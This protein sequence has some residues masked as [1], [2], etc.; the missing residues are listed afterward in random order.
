MDKLA[1]HY[2]NIPDWSKKI[3]QAWA[4][5]VNPPG[6]NPF[7]GAKIIGRTYM[8]DAPS[9]TLVMRGEAGARIWF[10][11]FRPQYE[12][13]AYVHAWEGPN[14]PPVQTHEQ[15]C[16]LAAFTRAW[17]S[18]MAGINCRTVILNL[19]VGWF[20]LGTGVDLAPA[21]TP[22]AT[23]WSTHEY[24]A[25]SMRSGETWH[26]LRYRRLYNELKPLVGTMPP[27]LGGEIG[28]DGGVLQNPKKGWRT[29]A[30]MGE[31]LAQL[32]WY[33]SELAKD[34]YVKAAFVFTAGPIGWDDFEVTEELATHIAELQ[35]EPL[36]TDEPPQ[37]QVGML[38]DKVRWW[39]EEA[40][41]QDEAG[42][43]AYSSR[44]RYALIR[45]D[46]GLLYRLESALKQSRLTG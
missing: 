1:I 39:M 4:K 42:N 36:P 24:S 10:E 2:Q 22:A 25:P 38:A 43:P 14:E 6:E 15:R 21:F 40:T 27:W 34:S 20:E 5:I 32:A 26:C 46:C 28:L 35:H 13:C 19:S 45:R 18:L 29:Y 30:E 41:R 31:Y 33:S 12:R 7:P 23:Y 11:N 37:I 3:P 9:N 17:T 44:I 8:D 16:A